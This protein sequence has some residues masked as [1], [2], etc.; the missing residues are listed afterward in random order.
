MPLPSRPIVAGALGCVA[1][2]LIGWGGL[3]VPSLIRSIKDAYDQSDAGIGVYYFVYAVAYATGSLGGGLVTERLGR[4]TVLS[5]A[6]ALY[7]LGMIALG[8]APIVGDPARGRDPGRA[9]RRS[10]RR[11]GQR[12]D[13]RPLPDRPRASAQPAAPVLQPRGARGTAGG[14]SPRGVRGRVGVDPRRVRRRRAGRG[15]GVRHDPHAIGTA[16]ARRRGHRDGDRGR[17]ACVDLGRPTARDAAPT[18]RHRD[19][20]LRRVRGR[21]LELARPVPRARAPDDRDDRAVALLG[22]PHARTTRLREDRGPVRPRHVRDRRSARH[23]ARAGGGR[24]GALAPAFGRAVRAGRIRDRPR[25]PDDRGDRRRPLSGPRR[26]G[27]RVPDRGG[28]DRLDRLSADHGLPVRD[29][30][31]D[32]RDAGQRPAGGAVCRR[33]VGGRPVDTRRRSSRPDATTSA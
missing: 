18:A 10:D 23:G 31:T 5:V 33:P 13:P 32:R 24:A 15:G 9:R 7:G 25:V 20:L 30:R 16:G 4:R 21:R 29:G 17:C 12:P 19:R 14:R 6:A 8:G 11:R 1:F 3:L 22:G 27:E 2:V 26:R 28:G